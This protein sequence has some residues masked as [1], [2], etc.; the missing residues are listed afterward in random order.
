VF[1]RHSVPDRL[2]LRRP[3]RVLVAVLAAVIAVDQ[4]SKALAV[5][6]LAHKGIRHVVGPVH[7]TLYRNFAGSGNRL[8]GHPVIVSLLAI[9][10]VLL[11]AVIASGASMRSPPGCCSAAASPTCS[12]A[13]CAPPDRCAAASWTGSSRRCMGAR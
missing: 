1:V 4:I 3:R 5:D 10:A 9:V 11:I 12:T 13:C 2:P 7:V 8:T 6:L